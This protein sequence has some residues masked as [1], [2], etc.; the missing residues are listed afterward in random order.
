MAERLPQRAEAPA[1]T[2]DDDNTYFGAGD[3]Y[4]ANN[5]SPPRPALAADEIPATP[6][7]EQPPPH[8]V[9]QNARAL[10]P[11]RHQSA[12]RLRRLRGPTLSS[13]L[14][15]LN[16][17]EQEPLGGRR[18]SSSEPQRP[19]IP[20]ATAWTAL[21]PVVEA[22]SHQN[23]DH[24]PTPV[25]SREAAAI[26]DGAPT[27]RRR[28]FPGRRHLTVQEPPHSH[29]PD[30]D[31]YDSRIVDILDVVGR[32]F[33]PTSWYFGMKLWLININGRPRSSDIVIH[34]QHPE[35]AVHT[36]SWKVG[37]PQAD[38]RSVPG[39]PNPRCFPP[40]KRGRGRRGKCRRETSARRRS[41]A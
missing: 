10:P 27:H 3:A 40:F 17:V 26:V 2:V 19:A 5:T 23:R 9:S 7:T 34:Y 41:V 32:F 24:V 20:T 16:N 13:G 36:L 28:H 6:T 37:E 22:Q 4:H 39:P 21:P 11:D 30:K 33:V 31:C 29:A 38:L 8:T 18:R 1:Q 12:I 15:P 14:L 35:F 25:P